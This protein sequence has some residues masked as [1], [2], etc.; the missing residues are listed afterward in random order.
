MEIE[1][2]DEGELAECLVPED[3]NDVPVGTVIA[4]LRNGD[5]E[6]APT[7]APAAPPPSADPVAAVRAD[8]AE[9]DAP[10]RLLSSPLARRTAQEA[11]I[12]LAGI[13][14]TGASG[15]I[16]RRDVLAA[17]DRQSATVA[18]VASAPV[19]TPQPA[20]AAQAPALP[21]MP[22]PPGATRVPHDRM[23][24]TI[25]RRLSESKATV[26]HFY[27]EA[28]CA[29][30]ALLALRAELNGAAPRIDGEPAF[31]LSVNDLVVRAYALALAAV[32]DANVA[33]TEDA[34]VRFAAVDVAVAV[35]IPGGLITPV[36]R[37][38]D[39]LSLSALSRAIADLAA[40][41]RDR[42]LRQDEIEGGAGTVSNLGMF[43]VSRFAAII[44]PPQA[45]ILAVGASR[46]S[47]E[48]RDGAVMSCARLPV[49]LS[50]D[51]RALD[52]AVAAQL[53][54]AFRDAI[55]TPLRLV[56]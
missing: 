4:R 13:T 16:V 3:S 32:P 33:W 29:F 31:K 20:P 53:L 6:P 36:V 45:S 43:G 25:A 5:A 7:P 18:A 49:T 52:G 54:A 2:I 30:D 34:M 37:N 9:A 21:D 55:E 24:L 41:A 15:R 48:M 50:V 38:A 19:A 44:N 28:D 23:R 39:R 14:A 26:P 22:L 46:E 35:A 47:L 8:K 42:A 40:R 51:H 11:G 17:I 27:L 12:A 1:A 10:P 56:A